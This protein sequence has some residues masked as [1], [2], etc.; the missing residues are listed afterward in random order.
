MIVDLPETS[1]AAVAERLVTLRGDTGAIALGR[2]LTLVVVADE[3]VLEG[4]LAAAAEASRQHPSRIVVLVPGGGRGA[5]R[6]DGQIRVGWD[7]GASEIVVLR[8][9]GLV[10]R[11][12]S[13][14]VV[15]LIL[16]DSPVLAWWP[17][18]PP[19]DL[20]DDPIAAMA[21]RRITDSAASANPRAMLRR[22][23][24]QY[25]PGDTDLAWTRVTTWRGVLAATLDQ[26]PYEPVTAA[27]VAGDPESP[28]VDLLAAWLG[29]SLRVPVTRVRIAHET[30]VRSVRLERPSGPIEVVRPGDTVATLT[31]PGQP[32]RSLP[33]K[34]R[35]LAEC[36]ADE[37]HR[38][39]PDEPYAAT[40]TRGLPALKVARR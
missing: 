27:E 18:T 20:G 19:R 4:A 25:R 21:G 6:L 17:S 5:S 8:L 22:L 31:Q 24:R 11:H 30:G 33:L 34:R 28:S 12:A 1:T 16:P 23:A 29:M 15:P 40:L 26:P 3:P 32:E 9:S 36:I 10:S 38:L 14:V 35:E 2:V 7:A 39:D 13:H 37:L